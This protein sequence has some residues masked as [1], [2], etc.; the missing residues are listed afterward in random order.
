MRILHTS[1]WHIGRTFH[2]ES[3]RDHLD[4]VLARI[5]VWVEEHDIDLV[6]VAGDIFDSSLPAAWAFT[7][8][9][10]LLVQIR[11]AGATV[12]LSS[13]NHDSSDRL[14]YLAPLAATAGVHIHANPLQP[15]APVVLDD[16]FGTV[17]LY[18]IPYLEPAIVRTQ[19]GEGASEVRTQADA[20][21]WAVS[22]INDDLAAHADAAATR[23]V[24]LAH[25]FAAG[26]PSTAPGTDLERDLSAGGLDVV[27]LDHFAPF[28]YVALG[29]IHS[30]MELRP[31]IRYSGAPLHYSFS[32]AGL[33]RGAW[34][35]DLDGTGLKSCQWLDFPIPR[36][37]Q[38]RSG[39]LAELMAM[40]DNDPLRN[41]W[42]QLTLTDDVRPTDAMLKLRTKFP[43]TVQ[44][45]YA[46]TQQAATA[47]G[48]RHTLARTRTDRDRI[49]AFLK[50]VRIGAATTANDDWS[51]ELTMID[52]LVDAYLKREAER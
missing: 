43:H 33:P 8:L 48:Y 6:C 20:I 40:D 12:V 19:G 30:K 10:E 36:A 29:H 44:L 34:L 9:T 4:A 50:H 49:V 35:V 15:C 16:E 46:P 37:L 5:P 11:A 3:V 27:P 7:A 47:T 13:G 52:E 45:R 22:Q 39:T 2:G 24:V 14:G 28:D 31:S 42:L 32:E 25:C 17:R 1:D 18:P 51:H 21:A 26:V 23:S 41:D 38:C